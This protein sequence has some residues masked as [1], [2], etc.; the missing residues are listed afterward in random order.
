MGAPYRS[1]NEQLIAITCLLAGLSTRRRQKYEK[2]EA[3]RE[4]ESR[5]M[6]KERMAQAE[7]KR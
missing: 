7:K 3:E 2:R 1:T 6:E 4:R 5:R